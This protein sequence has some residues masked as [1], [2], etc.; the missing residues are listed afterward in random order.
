MSCR[1]TFHSHFDVLYS[2]IKLIWCWILKRFCHVF[3]DWSRCDLGHDLLHNVTLGM[4]CYIMFLDV[5]VS[6]NKK[7]VLIWVIFISWFCVIQYTMLCHLDLCTDFVL[8]WSDSGFLLRVYM[9]LCT[10]FNSLYM[11]LIRTR[12]IFCL[13]SIVATWEIR[14]IEMKTNY[15]LLLVINLLFSIQ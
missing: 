1:V 15:V 7:K 2:F 14:M 8:I 4:T 12:I 6:L 13:L 3:P 5:S 9:Y 11:Y 10:F